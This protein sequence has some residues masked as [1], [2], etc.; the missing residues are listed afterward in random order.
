MQQILVSI[1]PNAQIMGIEPFNKLKFD[2]ADVFN[3]H[4]TLC[5]I[6][7]RNGFY[8]VSKSLSLGESA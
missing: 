1:A 2:V 5:R 6:Y 8:R 7:C 4:S 3:T